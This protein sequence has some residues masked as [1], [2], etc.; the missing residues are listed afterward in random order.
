VG[1][2]AED[3]AMDKSIKIFLASACVATLLMA[4]P[5]SAGDGNRGEHRANRGQRLEKLSERIN[6]RI[7]KLQQR[8]AAHPNAPAA[9]KT[10]ADKL[11][12]DLNDAA[13]DVEKI[14]AAL[15][16]HDKAALQGLKGELKKDHETI[17]ADREA[18]HAAV[19]EAV[20]EIRG[21]LPDGQGR[22]GG[23]KGGNA[24]GA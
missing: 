4:L 22:R 21:M 15:E 23:H 3:L 18:L 24:V 1:N 16:A 14:K 6:E 8:I 7:A 19:K 13:G 17:K 11:I 10:A 2:E 20:K 12:A 5:A 9:V